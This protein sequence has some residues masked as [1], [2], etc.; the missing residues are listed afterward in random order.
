MSSFHKQSQK[1]LDVL[2]AD[3]GAMTFTQISRAIKHHWWQHP[4]S[5]VLHELWRCGLVASGDSKDYYPRTEVW[6]VQSA[7]NGRDLSEMRC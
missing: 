3:G 6:W 1:V 7:G 5:D 4:T 2:S